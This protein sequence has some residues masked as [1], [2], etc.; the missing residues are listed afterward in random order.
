MA[1]SGWPSTRL[2]LTMASPSETARCWSPAIGASWTSADLPA[3]AGRSLDVIYGPDSGGMIV[4][5]TTGIYRGTSDGQSWTASNAGLQ[6][7]GQPLAIRSFA[8]A[9]KRPP[10][11][12]L[13]RGADAIRWRGKFAS[14]VYR[15]SDGGVR[16]SAA[17][18][19]GLYTQH[20]GGF[21]P[22]YGGTRD[23]GV[24]GG[25]LAVSPSDPNVVYLGMYAE[26]FARPIR[27]IATSARTAATR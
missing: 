4:G 12:A 9:Y 3:G 8:G 17:G 24:D 5:T 25:A 22:E 7:A 6:V 21:S 20:Y 19:A 2:V 10:G 13:R 15:S 18:I 27:T 16:S 23:D 1:R 14:C 11:S 26:Q